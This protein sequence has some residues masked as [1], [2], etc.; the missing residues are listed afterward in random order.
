MLK[1]QKTV[2]ASASVSTTS[3]EI[4]NKPNYLRKAL[5]VTNTSSSAV[6]TLAKG[7]VAAVAGAGIRLQPNSSYIEST[8]SG[9][10]CWQGA[11][12]AVADGAGTVAIVE[13]Y[14]EK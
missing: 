3:A 14:E 12:Q 7:D 9:F 5:I 6:V 13:T 8:D 1:I 11:I 10:T 4:L 2:N